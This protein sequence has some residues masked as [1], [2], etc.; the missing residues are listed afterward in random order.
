MTPPGNSSH[1]LP[2][3]LWVAIATTQRVT[4]AGPRV[5]RIPAGLPH[6]TT[7]ASGGTGARPRTGLVAGGWWHMAARSPISERRPRPTSAATQ[8]GA[9]KQD[10]RSERRSLPGVLGSPPCPASSSTL[11]KSPLGSRIFIYKMLAFSSP[12]PAAK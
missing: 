2:D 10:Q 1:L 4:H 12:A 8:P 11:S 9:S 3:F 5:V 6:Y 7:P